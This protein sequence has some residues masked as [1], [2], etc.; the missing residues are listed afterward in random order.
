MKE[1]QGIL[2][3]FSGPSGAG[4]GTVLGEYFKRCPDTVY[5][6]SATTRPPRP[7]EVD[8]THY[9]F[10]SKAAFEAL[11]DNGG[12]LEYTIYNGHYYGSPAAPIRRELEQGR[13]V[14]LEIEVKGALQVRARFP[15][16]LSIFV[17]PPSFAELRR[18]LVGRGTETEEEIKYRLMTARQEV[19]MAADYDYIIVNDVVKDAAARLETIIKAAKCSKKFS[20][21][22]IKEVLEDA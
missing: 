4:K 14:I 15:E 7:G 19:A 20:Q 5:S 22:F 6:I 8:G 11:I 13:D 18:R 2:V 1:H 9:H 21:E 10:L 16:A 17:M 12:V 3:V